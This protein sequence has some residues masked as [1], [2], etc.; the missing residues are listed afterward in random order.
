MMATFLGCFLAVTLPDTVVGFFNRTMPY[1]FYES[2]VSPWSG[3]GVCALQL[4]PDLRYQGRLQCI[5]SADS[6]VLMH[7]VKNSLIMHRQR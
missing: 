1:W 5:A 6:L 2:Q 4:Q 7:S 3:S